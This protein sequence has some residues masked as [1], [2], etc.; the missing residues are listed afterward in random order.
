MSLTDAAKNAMLDQF[1]GQAAYASLHTA[2]P[3][4]TGVN[5]VSGGSPAYAR[6]AMAWDAAAT[7]ALSQNEASPIDFDVPASTITH[8]GF[9]TAVTGGTFLCGAAL[10]SS[11]TYNAQGIHTL[12]DFDLSLS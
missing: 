10:S 8:V 3:G 6:Q 9:W 1:S 7:G 2:D 5:E 12:T 4:T 11:E